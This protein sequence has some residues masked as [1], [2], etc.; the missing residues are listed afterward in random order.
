[1]KEGLSAFMRAKPSHPALSLAGRL[2]TVLGA[3]IHT[4]GG[5]D[6]HM[7]DVRQ[8]GNVS[9]SGR[10]A[11]QLVSDDLARAVRILGKQAPEEALCGGF[12]LCFWIQRPDKKTPQCRLKNGTHSRRN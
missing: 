2:V 5:F 8:F 6:E 12:V 9:L 4:S 3:V 10:V 1:M 11:A 7:F